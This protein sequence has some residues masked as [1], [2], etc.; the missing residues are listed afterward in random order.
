[1][2]TADALRGDATGNDVPASTVVAAQASG[3]GQDSEPAMGIQQGVWTSAG[4]AA[5]PHDLLA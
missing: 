3:R 4:A 1:M 2:F 5:T